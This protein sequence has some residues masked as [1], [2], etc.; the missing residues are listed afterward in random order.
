MLRSLTLPVPYRLPLIPITLSS[1][2][3]ARHVLQPHLF[4]QLFAQL[5]LLH[6]AA[7]RERERLDEADELRDFVAA[8]SGLAIFTDFVCGDLFA[9]FRPHQRAD[10][11][12]HEFIGEPYDL[13]LGDL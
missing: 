9:L 13:G 10:L 7:G 3:E 4:D 11:F 6:L 8:D 12:P 5:E 1:R 2:L